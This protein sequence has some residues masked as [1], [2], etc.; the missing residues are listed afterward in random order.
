M[1][2]HALGTTWRAL[3][4]RLF[5]FCIAFA[6]MTQGSLLIAQG[7]DR[8]GR[9]STP[10]IVAPELGAAILVDVKTRK[11]TVEKPDE[12]DRAAVTGRQNVLQPR[13]YFAFRTDHNRLV[14]GTSARRVI[15]VR[16]PP[17]HS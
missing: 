4:V 5:V 1:S 14:Q 2:Q 15:P 11:L 8:L 13:E 7:S 16:G 17:R 10:S 6:S 3:T 9:D 12:S